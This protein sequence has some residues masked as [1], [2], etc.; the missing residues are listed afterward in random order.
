MDRL[1]VELIT[2]DFSRML[3]DLA[4]I[5]ITV[6]FSAV[7][8]SSAARV[9]QGALNRTVAAKPEK[10]RRDHDSRQF[11]S[12]NGRTYRLANRLPD[13][14]WRQISNHR[15]ARLQQKLAARGLAKQNWLHLHR[16]I[17]N[18]SKRGGFIGDVRAPSYVASANRLG[19]QYPGNVL[20]VSRGDAQGYMREIAI[21]SPLIK[22]GRMEPALVFAMAGETRYYERNCAHR[23]YLTH[24]SRAAK[25]PGVFVTPLPFAATI[26]AGMSGA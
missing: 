2:R 21:T 14:V 25:Y 10:I 17:R 4:A 23:F 19:E 5:D 9:S 12:F 20:T 6:E 24:A 15:A 8:D 3:A 16:K 1:K 26:P 7:V 13:E 11:T 18:D 22:G